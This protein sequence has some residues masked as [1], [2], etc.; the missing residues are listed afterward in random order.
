MSAETINIRY[1]PGAHEL[2]VND[3]GS[4]IDLYTYEDVFIEAG[5]I[6]L[7]DLGVAMKL[8]RNYEAILAPRYSTQKRWGLIQANSIGI[9]DPTYCGNED[10]WMWPAYNCNAKKDVFIP[11]GTRLCQFR[12]QEVQPRIIFNEVAN[13]SD[14]TRG[15]F[16][17]SG[18]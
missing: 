13:L 1:K 16:G 2:W 15:G 6:K 9:I 18:E 4:W 17:T 10:W 12:I 5:K 3:N 11:A 7:I 14:K 8:P